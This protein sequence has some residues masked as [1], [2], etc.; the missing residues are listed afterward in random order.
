MFPFTAIR[1]FPSFSAFAGIQVGMEDLNLSLKP[2]NDS[3]DIRAPLR[4]INAGAGLD[5]GRL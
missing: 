4:K 1:V 3:G 5:G 2:L